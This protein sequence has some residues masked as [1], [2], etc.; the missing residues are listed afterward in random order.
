MRKLLMTAASLAVL[1]SGAAQ[2]IT[3]PPAGVCPAGVE[4]SVKVEA[5]AVDRYAAEGLTAWPYA[6]ESWQRQAVWRDFQGQVCLYYVLSHLSVQGVDAPVR[7]EGWARV[8]DG[9]L[10]GF[11]D[12]APWTVR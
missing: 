10:A 4:V 11:S 8:I 7:I 3:I 9:A 1:L 5:W 6:P 2:A 12:E